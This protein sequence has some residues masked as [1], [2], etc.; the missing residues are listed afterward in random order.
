MRKKE[1]NRAKPAFRKIF[2]CQL[3]FILWFDIFA[4]VLTA[5][6]IHILEKNTCGSIYRNRVI[7]HMLTKPYIN[8][9]IFFIEL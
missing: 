9:Y 5:Y 7:V 1:R 6:F 2:L 8:E 3:Y 4:E